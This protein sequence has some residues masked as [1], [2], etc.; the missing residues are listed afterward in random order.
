[1]SENE[2]TAEPG[3]DALLEDAKLVA[4]YGARAGKLRNSD[5]FAAIKAIETSPSKTWTT[6]EAVGLHA[7]LNQAIA[8]IA[9]ATLRDLQSSDP[10]TTQASRKTR[11]LLLA[12]SLMLM[13]VTGYFTVLYNRGTELIS[14]LEQIDASRPAEK[15]GAV[16]RTWTT[17]TPD[18]ISGKETGAASETYYKLLDEVRELDNKV[19]TYVLEYAEFNQTN[20]GLRAFQFISGLAYA[21]STAPVAK[22]GPNVECGGVFSG[23]VP[24]DSTFGTTPPGSILAANRALMVN[25]ACAESLMISPYSMPSLNQLGG[26]VRRKMSI[27]SQW[28]LPALYGA[29]GA[30]IFYMRAVLN[31]ILPDPPIEKIIHRVALGAFAGIIFAWFWTPPPDAMKEFSGLSVNSFAIAF[32]IGFGIDV[33]FTALDRFVLFLQNM[34]SQPRPIAAPVQV[35]QPSRSAIEVR[36]NAAFPA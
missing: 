22:D 3:F 19:K 23:P 34:V 12:I 17:A 13:V 33:F 14:R 18:K 1:M 8:D 28:V 25:F 4:S 9:P 5:L 36:R 27:Y 15:M 20:P 16:A 31:P 24:A 35:V 10:F 32:L 29:L 2:T 7:A 26:E 30:L 6:A 21:S 11:F